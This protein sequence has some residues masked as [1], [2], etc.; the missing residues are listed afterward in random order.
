MAAMVIE[1]RWELYTLLLESPSFLVIL[2]ASMDLDQKIEA[3]SSKTLFFP[4]EEEKRKRKTFGLTISTAFHPRSFHLFSA[5][6]SNF[7]VN[8]NTQPIKADFHLSASFAL[9]FQSCDL[10]SLIHC[11]WDKRQC[12]I[13]RSNPEKF[14]EI[15][16]AT[17]STMEVEEFSISSSSS[18]SPRFC[19]SN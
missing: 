15:S 4:S 19:S 9:W 18:P 11:R 3:L 17:R 16:P 7:C 13:C 10:D 12:T 2:E 8:P 6:L 1:S 14:K 5:K